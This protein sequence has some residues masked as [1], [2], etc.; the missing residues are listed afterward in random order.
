VGVKLKSVCKGRT[1]IESVENKVLRRMFGS[2]R[3]KRGT[4]LEKTA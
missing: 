1:K 3:G 4:R 2:K